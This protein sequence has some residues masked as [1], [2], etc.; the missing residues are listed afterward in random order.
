ME[1]ENV[2]VVALDGPDVAEASP[3]LVPLMQ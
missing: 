1:P 2:V 3:D